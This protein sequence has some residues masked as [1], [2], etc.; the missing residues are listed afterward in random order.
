MISKEIDEQIKFF[1]KKSF[2]EMNDIEKQD[3]TDITLNHK[4]FR[5]NNTDINIYE[6][7]QLP[8]LKTC[9]INGFDITEEDI[10]D[11]KKCKNLK[12]I[13]FSNCN[14]INTKISLINLESVIIDNCKGD[15]EKIFS[16]LEELTFIQIVSNEVFNVSYIEKSKN[17]KKIYIQDTT[18]KKLEK[19]KKFENLEYVNLNQS[20]FSK[21]SFEILKRNSKFEIDYDKNAMIKVG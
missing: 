8:N 13:Q 17:L 16:K 6:L 4:D 3:I 15:L 11:L 9:T 2:N 5:G 1:Y 12:S 14:F 18:I 21:I 20:K 19:L 7:L 10:R